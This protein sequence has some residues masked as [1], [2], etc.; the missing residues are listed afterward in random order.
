MNAEYQSRIY[1]RIALI[2]LEG[3]VGLGAMLLACGNLAEGKG[4][5]ASTVGSGL[6]SLAAYGD[7]NRRVNAH[8]REMDM[9]FNGDFIDVTGAEIVDHS[10]PQAPPSQELELPINDSEL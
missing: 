7:M 10:H 9:P 2:G 1:R 3:V 5:T 8:N 6:L 4:S